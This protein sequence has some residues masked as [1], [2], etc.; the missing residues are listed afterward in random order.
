MRFIPITLVALLLLLTPVS[1]V[2]AQA[3]L[4]TDVGAN[5]FASLGAALDGGHDVD[6]DG[7]AD[8]IVGAPGDST[9]GTG[10][11]AAMVIAGTDG[12]VLHG[13]FGEST[14]DDFGRAVALIG[15]LTGD[16]RS[17]FLVGAPF[18]DGPANNAGL[19][20]VFDGAD[21][22]VLFE[23]RGSASSDRL[24]WA[25]DAAGDVDLDGVPDYL[26]SVPRI[27]QNGRVLVVSGADGQV[28]RELQ[29]FGGNEGTGAAIAGLGDVNAD[30]HPDQAVTLELVQ[31]VRV[32]SGLDGSLLAIHQAPD[33]VDEWG[34]SLGDGGDLDG[35]GAPELIIGAPGTT[36]SQAD[37][38]A[39]L[40]LSAVSGSVLFDVVGWQGFQR[41]GESVAGA[42]DVDG[43][44]VPDLLVGAPG[45]SVLFGGGVDSGRIQVLSGAT[46][47]MIHSL[48]LL[49][50]TLPDRLGTTVAA[51][52]DLDG[53]GVPDV[54][55]GAPE[56]SAFSADQGRFF[57]WSLRYLVDEIQPDAV[58]CDQPGVVELRGAGFDSGLPI[59]VRVGGIEAS[60]V[61]WL[62]EGRVSFVPPPGVPGAL[63]EVTYEQAGLLVE[64]RM[65]LQYEGP[66]VLDVHPRRGPLTGGTELSILGRHFHGAPEDVT[67]L[68][69]HSPTQD[70]FEC[71]VLEV[72]PPDRLR[73]RTPEDLVDPPIQ[74][75]PVHVIVTTLAGEGTK[76]N[77]FLYAEDVWV[78]VASASIE[79]G[80][81]VTV[82]GEIPPPPSG[83]YTAEVAG[84]PAEVLSVAPHAVE[85]RVPPAAL[86][87]GIWQ[88]IKLR[89]SVQGNGPNAQGTF[90]FTPFIEAQLG[91]D[92]FN[93]GLDLDLLIGTAQDTAPLN[94]VLTLWIV[95]V[96]APFTGQAWGAALAGASSPVP[97]S[98][99]GP[100]QATSASGP[101]PPFAG[102]IPGPYGTWVGVPTRLLLP[103]QAL[104]D[105]VHHEL[106][107]DFGPVPLQLLG[108]TLTVQGVV[109]SSARPQGTLTNSFEL[110]LQ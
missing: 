87:S 88:S 55:G 105:G 60:D 8:L 67:L 24:G 2:A 38:G 84:L 21:G 108:V 106:S 49:D 83:V 43:D 89:D 68:L 50:D 23:H 61:T 48:A 65:P 42:G 70:P 36:L 40:V 9:V 20:R 5:A 17:E 46:G 69:E 78:D 75:G 30:G 107:M 18:A 45:S 26:V 56:H 25:V 85:V 51:A 109:R 99:A 73:V 22:S 77:G 12:S 79:G 33:W 100:G 96:Q 44:G 102:R 28:L 103:L 59:V 66:V 10:H 57:A 54:L 41:L 13:V 47:Q 53:D 86:A 110:L 15:D 32:F 52:G 82:Q 90:R 98:P 81:I 29:G 4:Q 76:P 92:T 71:V 72:L 64:A 16:G 63:A 101:T 62:D 27:G 95:D 58:R 37:V 19:A 93:G 35:D 94:K 97:G 80:E 104:G 7:L 34:A 1:T 91:G 14:G 31:Q 74:G 11:G 3:L 39:V 6:G